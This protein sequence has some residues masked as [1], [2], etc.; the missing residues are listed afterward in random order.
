VAVFLPAGRPLNRDCQIKAFQIM[1]V[2]QSRLED[3]KGR[4]DTNQILA[5]DNA[6][7]EAWG[8]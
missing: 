3:Y 2:D 8:L 5:L 4:L 7:R 6:M 1:T